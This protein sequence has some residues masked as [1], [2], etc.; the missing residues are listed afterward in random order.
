MAPRMV[1]LF[2]AT[3]RLEQE[4]AALRVRQAYTSAKVALW[5]ARAEGDRRPTGSRRRGAGTMGQL[6]DHDKETHR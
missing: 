5:G 2:A 4:L 1:A 6:Q 3:P